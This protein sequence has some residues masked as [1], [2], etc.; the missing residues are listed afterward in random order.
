MQILWSFIVTWFPISG[1]RLLP[2]LFLHIV[3][4]L[5]LGQQE[6]DIE[7]QCDPLLLLM[8]SQTNEDWKNDILYKQ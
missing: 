6:K 2:M 1:A 5:E 7:K 8:G 4:I 3:N